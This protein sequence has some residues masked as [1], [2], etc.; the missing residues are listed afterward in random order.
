MRK[1]V[2]LFTLLCLSV[3]ILGPAEPVY[4]YSAIPISAPSAVLLDNS[5]QRIVY[6]KTPHMRR[7]PASTTK[8]LTA[9]VVMDRLPLNRRVTI[10][11]FVH[12]IEPSKAYLRG[13]ERYYVRDLLRAMLISSA[14][15]AAEVL[16]VAAHG[17]RGEFARAM[18]AKA[19]A[20]GC[21]HSHFLNASGLPARGQY[22]TAYDMALIM[23]G[24]QNY[25]FIV[26]TLKTRTLVIKSISGR[27]IYLKNHNKML[28]RDHREV[29]GKT[30]WTRAA[31]HCFVGKMNVW[32]K[33]VFVAL[34]GSHRLWRDLKILMDYQF[35]MSLSRIR[36]N[37]RLWS[38]EETRRIQQALRRAGFDPGPVD[39]EFGPRTI[40][41]VE[42]FQKAHRLRSDGIVSTQTRR[43]L[44][45]Y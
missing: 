26:K 17:T 39:G 33:D 21:R 3:L 44:R 38:R 40:R 16:A 8:L 28:W 41:A 35:G 12:E 29:I 19:H 31:K 7:S 27:R 36:Q 4:A 15:D 45:R 18:N 5:T 22:S 37:R 24:A 42:R 14:N 32:S 13:G 25:S 11:S 6:A 30:G 2:S 34:M 9:M 23:R 20:I 43:K 10:P 1:A